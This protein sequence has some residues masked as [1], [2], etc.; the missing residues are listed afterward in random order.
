MSEQFEIQL[1]ESSETL[2]KLEVMN[3]LNPDVLPQLSELLGETIT[4]KGRIKLAVHNEL[5][6]DGDIDY[7]TYVY[8]TED[9]ASYY[10]SSESFDSSFLTI[11]KAHIKLEIEGYPQIQI[12][13]KKSKNN[14]GN[15]LLAKA[16][17]SN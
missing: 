13:E 17:Y 1:V 2:S 3:N 11:E 7:N 4:V 15:M 12:V 8:V 10:T 5:N 6:K 9:G 16:A 14:Q